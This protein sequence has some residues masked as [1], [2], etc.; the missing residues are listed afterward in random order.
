MAAKNVAGTSLRNAG[1][2]PP[3]RSPEGNPIQLNGKRT[4]R[5]GV[6]PPPDSRLTKYLKSLAADRFVGFELGGNSAG[7][8][9]AAQL[10]TTLF[11]GIDVGRFTFLE[12]S[13]FLSLGTNNIGI[14]AHIE[15]VGFNIGPAKIALLLAPNIGIT[16][17]LF[18]PKEGFNFGG[19][20]GVGIGADIAL[21]K[22]PLSLG[23][24]L[25]Y[26]LVQHSIKEG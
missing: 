12:I 15:P 9:I 22:S 7:I 3:L 24:H 11:D 8:N 4:K 17:N 26:N 13:T 10:G 21:G 19:M 25:T 6:S 5:D 14:E 23:L 16:G 2:L 1:G 18:K 20:L